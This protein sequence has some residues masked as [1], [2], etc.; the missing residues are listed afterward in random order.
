M[1]FSIRREP[2]LLRLEYTGTLTGA[3]L[4]SSLDALDQEQRAS[5]PWPNTLADLRGVELNQLSFPDM[6]SVAKR[7]DTVA[8]ANPIR[9]ALVA[10]SPTVLGFCRMFQS[11][12]QNPNIAVQVFTDIDEAV[13]WLTPPSN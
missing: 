1:P 3:E 8:P 12:M 9:T 4:H 6:M 5:S 11:L 13:A 10:D 2:S 7:R